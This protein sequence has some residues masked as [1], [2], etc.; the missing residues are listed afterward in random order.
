MNIHIY[1]VVVADFSIL[2]IML[3]GIRYGGI[4]PLLRVPIELP[5]SLSRSCIKSLTTLTYLISLLIISANLSMACTVLLITAE[6]MLTVSMVPCRVCLRLAVPLVEKTIFQKGVLF[7]KLVIMTGN[8]GV[9]L[10]ASEA[11]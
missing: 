3:R 8:V 9:C 7:T 10:W 4:L 11:Y 5:T 6:C 2:S 1:M